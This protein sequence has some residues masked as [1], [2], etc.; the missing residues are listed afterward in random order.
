MALDERQQKAIEL[1][2]D[3][4]MKIA[5]IA[6]VCGV[7]RQ[8]VHTWRT[9]NEEFKAGLDRR[10]TA[11]KT[12]ANEKINSSLTSVV[13]ELIRLALSDDT[14]IREK[15]DC[16]QYLCNRALGTPTSSVNM[17]IDD[18]TEDNKSDALAEFRAYVAEQA[19]KDEKETSE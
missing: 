9:E 18:K 1:L 5:D 6:K 12:E 7:S 16:L 8:T 4:T 11:M 13:N 14:P 10:M 2:A 19:A 3:G 15:K 17:E